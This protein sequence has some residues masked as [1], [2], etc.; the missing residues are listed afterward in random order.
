MIIYFL[1]VFILGLIFGSFF[2]VLIY[3]IPKKES[4]IFPPSHCPNCNYKIKFYDNIPVL[5]Y[6][7]LG[8]KC[9]NCKQKISIIYPIIELITGIMFVSIFYLYKIEWATL[10]YIIDF[11]FLLVLS[12][13]DYNTKEVNVYSLIFP[14]LITLIF[15]YLTNGFMSINKQILNIDLFD[16]IIGLLLGMIL[17]TLVRFI[18]TKIVKKEA[19]GEADIYIAGFM[20]I[21]LGYQ[22]FFIAIIVSGISGIFY[23]FITKNTEDKEIPFIPFLSLG[24]FIT[25]IFQNQ[26]LDLILK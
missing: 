26:L 9:R 6:I 15:I 10:I 16:S 20:G 8:G 12:S 1:F 21:L 11:S 2:N 3:R 14:S 17:F 19:M 22:L 7:F 4:I 23:Y 25:F 24:T 18:G 5:S 13:I